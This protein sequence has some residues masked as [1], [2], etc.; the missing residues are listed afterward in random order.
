MS[1]QQVMLGIG[2]SY[3][4]DSANFDGSVNTTA[5][6]GA[7]MT[8]DADSQKGLFCCWIRAD[9]T[10]GA[11]QIIFENLTT[12]GG[13]GTR[14]QF[15]ITSGGLFSCN[16]FDS[17]G[18]NNFEMHSTTSFAASATWRQALG[19][20]DHGLGRRQ[21]Y[22]TDAAETNI[23]VA[24]SP[25]V[26]YAASDWSM[27]AAG[28]GIQ[29]FTGCLADLLFWEG[30]SVDLSVTANRR[31]FISAAGKPV[32]PGSNGS[33]PLGGVVPNAFFHLD[34]AEA[35]ANFLTNRGSG[36][37]FTLARGTMTTG[38]SSPSD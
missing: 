24:N 5:T 35:V 28:N 18:A 1:I 17:A 25:T 34:K 10:P 15:V 22:I 26:G 3:L 8:G 16:M 32:P 11:Q 2:G 6:R 4:V 21:L 37:N 7:Q 12:V 19:T 30:Q 23:G 27:G 29:P 20:W 14:C 13:S 36:G 31:F 38:S 9:T 33:V